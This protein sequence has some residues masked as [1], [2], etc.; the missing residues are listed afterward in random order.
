MKPEKT[1]EYASDIAQ[2]GRHL[3]AVL[4]NVLDMARIESGK[5][6]LEDR[7]VRLGDVVEYAIA[8]LGGRHAHAGKEIRTSGDDD[9]ILRGDEVKLRQVVIN[10]VSNALKFTVEGDVI[11]IRIERNADGVDL[12][13]ED[14]GEGIPAD[15]LPIIMEPFGQAEGAYARSH[16]GVGLGLP[17]VKSLVELHGGRFT[18]ESEVGQGTLA[19]SHLPRERLVD[20]TSPGVVTA[21]GRAA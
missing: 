9:V 4:N 13:V 3:L 15:K 2:G 10:L 16:G 7:L 14:N 5:V 20:K 18:I 17:I 6:E 19:R 1:K 21:A 8:V 11:E 12:I